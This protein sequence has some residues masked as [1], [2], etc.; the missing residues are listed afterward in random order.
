M[1]LN[2]CGHV[3]MASKR[4]HRSRLVGGQAPVAS[5]HGLYAGSRRASSGGSS[6]VAEAVE[7]MVGLV[8]SCFVSSCLCE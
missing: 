2:V 4:V 5:D 6:S 1:V 3:V 8:W 7:A